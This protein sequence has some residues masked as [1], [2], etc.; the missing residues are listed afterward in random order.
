MGRNHLFGLT[1]AVLVAALQHNCV[2][3]QAVL[4][5]N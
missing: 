1:F 5:Q 4:A 3:L 2:E